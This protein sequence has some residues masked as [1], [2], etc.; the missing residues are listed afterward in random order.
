MRRATHLQAS[1]RATSVDLAPDDVWTVVASGGERSRWYVDAGPFVVRGAI[2]RVLGGAGRRWPAQ[3][4]ALLQPGDRG[5]FWVVEEADHGVRRLV[6]RAAVRAP[7]VVRLE[8][9]VAADGRGSSITTTVSFAPA[10]LVGA[11]YLL[12]DLPARELVT[13]LTH[14]R[15]VADVRAALG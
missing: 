5:G 1:V 12:T 9:T 6:L 7:G 4:G 2:D 8:C 15:I 13:E 3:G 10:G 11:A 14:R